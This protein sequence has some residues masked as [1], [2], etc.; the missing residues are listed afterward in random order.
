MPPNRSPP[1][2][3]RFFCSK[4]RVS[5][6]L[7]EIEHDRLLPRRT[8]GLHLLV[9]RLQDSCLPSSFLITSGAA[10]LRETVSPTL[11]RFVTFREL[12]TGDAGGILS[13]T[14]TPC[15]VDEV[16]FFRAPSLFPLSKP[17]SYIPNRPAPES[18]YLRGAEKIGEIS[19]VEP[20]RSPP[21]HFAVR[22]S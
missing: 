6:H 10:L 16:R 5:P 14:L 15:S 3:P 17:G 22:P 11:F 1:A 2:S 4:G 13:R 18:L 19:T 7:V 20:S 9:S 21:L 12:R 8:Y